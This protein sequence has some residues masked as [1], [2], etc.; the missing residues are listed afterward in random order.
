MPTVFSHIAFPV[1]AAI[2]AG[3]MRIPTSMLLVGMLASIVPDFDGVAFKLGIA[4]GGMWGHR[5]YTHTLGFALVLGLL[6][7]LLFK[8]WG[9]A[10]WKAYAWVALCTFSHPIADSFTNGGL[11]IPLYWPITETRF[12]SPWTPVEV[13]PIA[14]KRFFSERGAN[15]LLNEA[16]VIWLPLLSLALLAFAYRRKMA[17]SVTT[18]R[19]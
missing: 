7:L 19:G 10:P 3:K 12:F 8:R 17:S 6:G 15:V 11:A 16:K 13:S 4:Y 2:A 5:G 14:L 18:Q 9:L 1:C